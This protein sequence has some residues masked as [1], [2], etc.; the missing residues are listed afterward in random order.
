MRVKS[1]LL[2]FLLFCNLNP[3]WCE[4]VR[5]GATLPLSG[6]YSFVGLA[7]QRGMQ[8]ALNE[9]PP[10]QI[11]IWYEDE[12]VVDRAKAV[13]GFQKLVSTNSVQ[14]VLGST[15][16]TVT[17]Y[18]P[19]A[20]QRKIPVITLWDS[21]ASLDKLGEYIF[22]I[23]YSTE[24]AGEKIARYAFEQLK[25]SKL[26][27]VSAHDEWS[28]LVASAFEATYRK[29]GG[30]IVTH[31]SVSMTDSDL[32]SLITRIKAGP[33]QGIFAPL[34]LNALSA[35]VRQTKEL[36]YKGKVLV[37]DGMVDADAQQLAASAEG[38]VL[39]QIWLDSPTLAEKYKKLCGESPSPFALSLAA[40]GYDGIQLVAAAQ[41]KLRASHTPLSPT[42]IRETLLNLDIPGVST[43]LNFQ[44]R[45]SIPQEESI[46]EVRSG[47]FHKLQD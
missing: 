38:V 19:I 47:K 21:N 45:R 25:L 4:S 15:V 1:F 10:G 20:A 27:L 3:A 33:A 23:G 31:E 14:V 39:T 11:E 17:A 5:V 29:L 8:I 26:A 42:T 30:E 7:L 36:G 24:R 13:T 9:L 44:G 41:A 22:S 18:A 37:A 35:L 12:G 32:R 2:G 16:N 46:V 43:R 6:D 34:Y 40:L 28:E